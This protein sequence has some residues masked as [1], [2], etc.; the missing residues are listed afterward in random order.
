MATNEI[1]TNNINKY[2]DNRQ[3]NGANATINR[4]LAALKRMF[5]IGFNQT[6]HKIIRIPSLTEHNVRTGYFEHHEYLKMCDVLPSHIKPVFIMGYRTGMRI[7]EILSLNWETVN[8]FDRRITLVNTKNNEP[9]IIP[10]VGELF[11]TIL[12]QKVLCDSSYSKF[13]YV[14]SRNRKQIKDFRGVW[15]AAFEKAAIERKLFH[16]LRRT[17]VRNMV[18]AGV[19]EKVSMQISG[20]KTRDVFERYHIVNEDDLKL[21]FQKV[22]SMHAETEKAVEKENSGHKTG[23]I[24]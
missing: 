7:S 23:T 4:E 11:D 14:F 17:A 12:K 13:P 3:K 21:A 15:N 16:D 24:G 9:R 20:H 18:R 5:S 10:L 6:P 1:T 22:D 19:A 8:I 2:I